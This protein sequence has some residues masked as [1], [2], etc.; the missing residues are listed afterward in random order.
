[1]ASTIE[2]LIQT[3]IYL[4]KNLPVTTVFYLDLTR[5]QIRYET[6]LQQLSDVVCWRSITSLQLHVLRS[7]ISYAY[8]FLNV[9]F[10]TVYLSSYLYCVQIYLCFFFTNIDIYARDFEIQRINSTS[11]PTRSDS[12]SPLN[13]TPWYTNPWISPKD[14][15]ESEEKKG[16]KVNMK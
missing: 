3:P 14:C 13:G 10:F 9:F 16:I 8:S 11:F 5:E 6:T 4:S 12:E 1:M 15:F 2:A 7:V